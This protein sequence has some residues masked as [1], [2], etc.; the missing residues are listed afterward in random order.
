M[1]S[2][3]AARKTRPEWDL[4]RKV[5]RLLQERAERGEEPTSPTAL[6]RLIPIDPGAVMDWI[7]RGA[8]PRSKTGRR[9]A[10]VL[11]VDAAWLL[12]DTAG[13]KPQAAAGLD[14]R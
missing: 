4:G 7:R 11:G 1:S 3:V 10:E 9:V 8:S 13:W 14:A 6:A 12:D 5:A 2:R